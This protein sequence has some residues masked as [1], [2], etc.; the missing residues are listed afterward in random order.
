MLIFFNSNFGDFYIED[1]LY[2]LCG[3]IDD[4][5]VDW[6]EWYDTKEEV[7][8]R[9]NDTIDSYLYRLKDITPD[10]T[11]KVFNWIK[12][13]IA[14]KAWDMD[15]DTYAEFFSLITNTDYTYQQFRGFN[16]DIDNDILIFYPTSDVNHAEYVGEVMSANGKPV[17]ILEVPNEVMLNVGTPNINSNLTIDDF[18]GSNVDHYTQWLS[19]TA[20]Y[21]ED[22]CEYLKLSIE[23]TYIWHNDNKTWE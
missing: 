14:N 23:D 9:C 8:G 11:T 7:D 19:A 15:E 22:I 3:D 13:R 17:T 6:D 5:L 18:Y 21:K 16:G 1:N 12:D 2:D 10:I 4:L 20:R